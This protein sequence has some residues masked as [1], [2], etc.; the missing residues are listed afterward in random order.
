MLPSLCIGDIVPTT[1]QS[2]LGGDDL[3]CIFRWNSGRS[4]QIT[5]LYC[6]VDKNM[7]NWASGKRKRNKKKLSCTRSTY[8]MCFYVAPSNANMHHQPPHITHRGHNNHTTSKAAALLK[9]PCSTVRVADRLCDQ[10]WESGRIRMTLGVP[11]R[12]LTATGSDVNWWWW[13]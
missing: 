5:L 12:W 7:Q 8:G 1:G 4:N 6:P 10:R 11:T 13:G 2:I 3:E 9:I